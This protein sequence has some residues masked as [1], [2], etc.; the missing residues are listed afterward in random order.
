MAL[1]LKES[2]ALF[3]HVPKTGGTW[4]RY[5]LDSAAIDYIETAPPDVSLQHSS[6][7]HHGDHDGPM[8]AFVR[9]PFDWYWSWF[10]FQSQYNWSHWEPGNWHPQR[11]IFDCASRSFGAFLERV[12]LKSPGYVSRMFEWYFGPPG[13]DRVICGRFEHLKASLCGILRDVGHDFDD[14]AI[15]D[16]PAANVSQAMDESHIAGWLKLRE[17]CKRNE[18]VA[19]ERFYPHV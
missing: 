11:E 19:Y 1:L 13:H 7:V 5:A 14:S 8:F 4:V 17:E 3:L 15:R 10:R 12:R 18:Q 9:D 2:N 6:L 16:T